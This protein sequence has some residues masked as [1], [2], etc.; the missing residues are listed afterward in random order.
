LGVLSAGGAIAGCATLAPHVAQGE[1]FTTGNATFDDFFAAVRE[2]RTEALAAPKDEAAAH[3]GLIK[4]LGLEPTAQTAMALDEAGLRAKK[5]QEKGILLHLEISPEPKLIAV[6]GRADL[7]P[8]GEALLH[9]ME[10]ATRTSLEMRKRLAA[11]AARAVELEKVRVDLRG[12]APAAFREDR[13]AKRDEIIT[14]LD[15]AKGVLA[16]ASDGA[17][18][19]AGAAARFVVELV[20]AAETGGGAM[21]DPVRLARAKKLP[22]VGT[23]A[24][25]ASGA[26][27]SNGHV[28]TPAPKTPAPAVP[29]PPP[30]KRPKGVDDFEP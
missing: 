26:P 20:Q 3:A 4:A 12:Q 19:S 9:A 11:V 7:G 5:L 22:G 6:H 2:V 29:A 28:A 15:A 30:Q 17:G 13:Q 18:R 21:L 16:D 14:E 1:A 24:K 27:A 25:A 10:D 8:D 23:P